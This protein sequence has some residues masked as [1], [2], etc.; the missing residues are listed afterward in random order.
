MLQDYCRIELPKLTLRKNSFLF[1]QNRN[2]TGDLFSP[3]IAASILSGNAG[4]Q[5]LLSHFGFS[6][7]FR[8]SGFFGFFSPSEIN[9][10][11]HGINLFGLSGLSRLSGLFGLFRLDR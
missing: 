5:S 6:R 7:F 4:D 2:P 3:R 1:L 8:F 11:F 10:K 9:T